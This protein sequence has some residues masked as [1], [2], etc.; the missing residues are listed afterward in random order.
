[1][2]MISL[3]R[4]KEERK[5]WRKDHP[6]GFW[7]KPVVNADGSTDLFRWTAGIPGREGT[8]WEG[9]VYTI[10]IFFPTDFP[11]QPPKCQFAP[12]LFHPN[13]FPSGTVCLSILNAEKGWKPAINLGQILLG[14]QDLLANPNPDDPAQQE[15]CLLLRKDPAGYEKRVREEVAKIKATQPA[16]SEESSD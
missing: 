3:N 10:N 14:I 7:A 5:V 2:S 4:L 13:V 9:A 8:P 6:P 16:S 15:P 12:V 11:S 1:M